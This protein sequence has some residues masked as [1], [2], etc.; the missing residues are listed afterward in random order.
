MMWKTAKSLPLAALSLPMAAPRALPLAALSLRSAA[1]HTGRC[2][3]DCVP[4]DQ[5]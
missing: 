3:A 5:L 4:V 1:R 2:S